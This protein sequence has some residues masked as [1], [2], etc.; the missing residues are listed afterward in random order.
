MI[1]HHTSVSVGGRRVEADYVVKGNRLT[2]TSELGEGWG[3]TGGVPNDALATMIL[4][5]P[6]HLAGLVLRPVVH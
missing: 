3:L 6:A 2:V 4:R 5:D 1:Q